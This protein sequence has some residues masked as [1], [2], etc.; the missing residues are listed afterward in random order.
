MSKPS[1]RI[2]VAVD[3]EH[4]IGKG[5]GIPW[6]SPADLQHFKDMTWGGVLLVGHN[7]YMSLPTL[8]GRRVAVVSRGTSPNNGRNLPDY[9]ASTYEALKQIIAREAPSAYVWVSGGES[10][11]REAIRDPDVK[12][13]YVTRISNKYQ[14]DRFFPQI[15]PTW[16]V[17][18]RKALSDNATLEYYQVRTQT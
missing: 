5:G 14:C 4:G 18:T 1:Y 2:I 11:Y 17:S 16:K 10:I 6:R 15:P 8:P 3:E 13:A 9:V 7:T 12:S